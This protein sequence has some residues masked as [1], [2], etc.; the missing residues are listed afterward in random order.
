M[1]G[2]F[3]KEN[4]NQDNLI[5]DKKLIPKFHKDHNKLIEIIESAHKA[6]E[7]DNIKK[8][9][10]QLMKL[11]TKLLEHFMEEDIKLY[12]YLKK[13]YKEDVNK[14]RTIKM[15]ETTIKDIQKDVL[16][17]LGKYSKENA[18]LDAEFKENFIQMVKKF[19]T[20]IKTEEEKLYT[21]YIK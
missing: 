20:R 14:L 9:K 5:Y 16:A 8:S 10:K 19:D 18:E 13:Y 6:I 15:F 4:K 21:L 12:N 3:K 7:A 11:R 1:F 2:L 17:F